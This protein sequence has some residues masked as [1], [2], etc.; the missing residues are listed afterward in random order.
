MKRLDCQE[1]LL[2]LDEYL[3]CELSKGKQDAVRAHLVCCKHCHEELGNLHAFRS[4]IKA[5]QQDVST[6]VNQKML[7]VIRDL[8]NKQR[9]SIAFNAK[10]SKTAL[11]FCGLGAFVT[12][13]FV[14]L[15]IG[16]KLGLLG[17]L[18][19]FG[20]LVSLPFLHQRMASLE[21]VI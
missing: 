12:T 5:I 1:T 6:E 2:L 20:G 13:M 11:L 15:P 7:G 9:Q 18:L 19:N 21:G 17:L 16:P 14:P 8:S 3:T 10:L 4:D